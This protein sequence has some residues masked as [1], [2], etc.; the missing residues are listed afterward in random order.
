MSAPAI[1]EELGKLYTQATPGLE[2]LF[3]LLYVAELA[4]S[5]EFD[6]VVV[7]IGSDIEASILTASLL[8]D[9]GVSSI[10]AKAVTDAHGNIL[11]RL[12]VHHVVYPEKDMGRKLAH[13]VR[14]AMQ[15]F[16]EIEPGFALIKTVAPSILVDR[17]LSQAGVRRDYG[18]T[19]S[20][21]RHG[22]APWEYTTAESVVRRAAR[23][24]QSEV[25]SGP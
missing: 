12:G 15:D 3:G 14:G 24:S 17:S 4:E 7:G 6:R 23:S 1:H 13:L 5:G 9:F 18:V 25:T 11:S 20:A 21:I 2:D 19:V 22:A 16:L 10:W 8:V